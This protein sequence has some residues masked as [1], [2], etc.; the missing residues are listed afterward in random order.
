MATNRL[1]QRCNIVASPQRAALPTIFSRLFR[2]VT[3]C[4]VRAPRLQSGPARPGARRSK[5]ES[6]DHEFAITATINPKGISGNPHLGYVMEERLRRIRIG[7]GR[8]HSPAW[9]AACH[10]TGARPR[11]GIIH[12]LRHAITKIKQMAPDGCGW[13]EDDRQAG[14]RAPTSAT[15]RGLSNSLASPGS[16]TGPRPGPVRSKTM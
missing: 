15:D 13:G 2:S 12:D 9:M 8:G 10:E 1:R 5:S 7:E 11:A 3:L 4:R 16:V 14:G 6:P